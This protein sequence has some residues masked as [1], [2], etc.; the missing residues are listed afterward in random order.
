VA[1]AKE[2]EPLEVLATAACPRYVELWAHLQKHYKPLLLTNT[3]SEE[4]IKAVKNVSP[5]LA[6]YP[7]SVN[8]HLQNYFHNALEP[9][10]WGTPDDDWLVP[11]RRSRRQTSAAAA[12][13]RKEARAVPPEQPLPQVQLLD[14]TQDGESGDEEDHDPL[15]S[16]GS[17]NSDDGDDCNLPTG[18]LPAVTWRV[19]AADLVE[20]ET[21]WC[22]DMDLK[23]RR[24]P[25]TTFSTSFP[26]VL[27][28]DF[29]SGEMVHCTTLMP[30]EQ[31]VAAWSR[32][33]NLCKPPPSA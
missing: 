22:W 12:K 11:T 10:A 1:Y 23:S 26:I 4:F 31:Y 6:V 9:K 29:E 27:S 33:R 7:E 30:S 8:T 25:Y 24:K 32:S 5:Q 13:A 17:D 3:L 19:P 28:R 21:F 18:E 14:A 2:V 15:A 16:D 20:G